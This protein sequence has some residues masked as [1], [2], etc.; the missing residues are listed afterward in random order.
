MNPN[1]TKKKKI[2][3]AVGRG[4]V[5]GV[6]RVSDFFFL[7]PNE[8]KSEKKNLFSF[9]GGEG[10]GGLASVMNLFYK[11]S[12]SEKKEKEKIIFLFC[13]VGGGGGGW[14]GKG[15]LSKWFFFFTRIHI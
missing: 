3:L 2:I 4:E 12:K 15:V 5:G 11:K 9:R 7:F 8:S 10:K 14:G 13:G 6:A 1:L